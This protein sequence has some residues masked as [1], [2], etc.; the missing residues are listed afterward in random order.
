M[1]SFF[2]LLFLPPPPS[3]V[4]TEAEMGMPLEPAESTTDTSAVMGEELVST[5]QSHF[6]LI[7][8]NVL[9]MQTALF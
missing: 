3:E 9:Q 5:V 6:I 4:M 1:Q 7:N 2:G 8:N